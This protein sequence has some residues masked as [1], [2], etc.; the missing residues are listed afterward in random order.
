MPLRINN[1]TS[2]VRV[3]GQES[4]LSQDELNRIV[5]T[6]LAQVREEMGH[7]QRVLNETKIRDGV[8]EVEPY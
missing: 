1:M 6:V 7:Q 8:S 3:T 4:P 2:N 5:N